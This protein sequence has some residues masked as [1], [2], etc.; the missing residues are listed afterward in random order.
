M[1]SFCERISLNIP[2]TVTGSRSTGSPF[3]IVSLRL[4][5]ITEESQILNVPNPGLPGIRTDRGSDP[6]NLAGD[7]NP[8]SVEGND[9]RRESDD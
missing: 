4:T 5:S 1:D 2:L 3:E 9:I 7:F 8:R 6:M